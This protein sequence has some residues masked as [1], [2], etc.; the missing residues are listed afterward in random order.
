MTV[1]HSTLTLAPRI[2][3]ILLTKASASIIHLQASAEKYKNYQIN[4]VVNVD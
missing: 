3:Y 4:L 2:I 1:V